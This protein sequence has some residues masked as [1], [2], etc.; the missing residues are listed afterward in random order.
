MCQTYA[1]H[2]IGNSGECDASKV[3]RQVYAVEQRNG[4]TYN[5]Y[6]AI[7]S[8][9]IKRANTYRESDQRAQPWWRHVLRGPF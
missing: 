8:L 7:N 5:V 2:A 6:K 4:S 1:R 3:K 9:F